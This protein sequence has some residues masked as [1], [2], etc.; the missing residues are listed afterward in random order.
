MLH[1][2]ISLV[3][4]GFLAGLYPAEECK[5]VRV[6]SVHHQGMKNLGRGLTVEASSDD[7]VVE[8]IRW[9]ESRA[10][11]LGLQWHPEYHDAQDPEMLSSK[12]IL[13]NFLREVAQRR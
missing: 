9:T 6:N 3:P 4:G 11:V 5:T 8:A 10:Y 13:D 7:G 2:P 12:P 1:H